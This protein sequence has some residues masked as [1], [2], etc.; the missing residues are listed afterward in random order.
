MMRL[1]NLDTRGATRFVEGA[2]L[3]ALLLT[4]AAQV[5]VTAGSLLMLREIVALISSPVRITGLEA[6]GVAGGLVLANVI[7]ALRTRRGWRAAFEP[8]AVAVVAAPDST[9]LHQV[10]QDVATALDGTAVERG[11][12]GC[13]L[14]GG[15]LLG[16]ET[17]LRPGA[18]G[19]L[20]IEVWH[21]L[22]G[23]EAILPDLSAAKW[24]WLDAVA[25]VL[26]KAT[27]RDDA[28]PGEAE[29]L[30]ADA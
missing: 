27:A 17:E 14:T 2:P 4:A 13:V 22:W 19:E 18:D 24:R 1:E 25:G 11:L 10:A 12:H 30:P 20:V 28:P 16:F 21:R 5:A 6:V 15:R 8:R 3:L 23:A 7:M 26:A 29:G 9:H